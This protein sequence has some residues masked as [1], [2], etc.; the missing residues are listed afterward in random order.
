M[1]PAALVAIVAGSLAIVG[2]IVGYA[3]FMVQAPLVAGNAKLEAEKAQV[4]AARAELERTLGN[5][6]ER[7]AE[8]DERNRTLRQDLVNLRLGKTSVFLKHE[9][10][11]ELQEAM[12]AL[13]VSES[14]ILVPGPAPSASH[15]VFLSIHG[16]AASK[17]RKAK[18]AL[19]KGIV[20]RVFASGTPHN[21]T[22]AYDDPSFFSGIDR[23]GEH[24]TQ[25][26]LTSPLRQNGRV[27][28]VVQ[29]LNKAGGFTQADEATAQ[30]Y[31]ALLAPKVATFARSPENFELLGLAW[32][33]EDRDATV[34]F[35]DLTSSSALLERMN[36]PSAIDC[37]NEYLEQQCDIAMRYG[38]TV[39]KYIGDG[40][41]LRFN[42]PRLIAHDDHAV[43]AVEAALEMRDAFEQLKESWVNEG[44]P[45]GDIYNRVGLSCGTVHEAKIGHPQ[46]QQITVIGAAVN[47]AANLC[48]T[49]TRE[50]NVVI[51]AERLRQRLGDRFV[52]RAVQD[53]THERRAFEVLGRT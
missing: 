40:A 22:N 15:F 37:I 30:E 48:E 14:S 31:A 8:L 29:F 11:A 18:L 45:V 53:D 13:D 23:K 49:A 47:D 50:G 28:G 38:A 26:M 33:S 39:D 25:A 52:V 21:T 19:D 2:A 12:A 35:C 32:Q 9:I 42:V 6:R 44:L 17:L 7:L 34:A 27:V 10:D 43:R 4:D 1:T 46:F 24:E 3:K 5:E 16:P 41:M 20:G 36:V 51:V